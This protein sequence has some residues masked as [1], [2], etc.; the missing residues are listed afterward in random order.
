[1]PVELEYRGNEAIDDMHAFNARR[2]G[3]WADDLLFRVYPTPERIFFIKIGGSKNETTGYLIGGVIGIL[4]AQFLH[5]GERKRTEER[6]TSWTGI[7]PA[8]LMKESKDN[9]IILTSNITEP[10]INP[11]SVWRDKKFGSWSFRDGN[12]K[13]RELKFEDGSNFREAVR[14][15][16][17]TFGDDLIVKAEWNE[18][19]QKVVKV[20]NQ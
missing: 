12:G 11:R 13:K 18:A 17:E 4:I 5:K 7:R 15:L 6:L 16:G 2:H 9:H 10:T 3:G 19:K 14:W 20:K 8:L 1:M